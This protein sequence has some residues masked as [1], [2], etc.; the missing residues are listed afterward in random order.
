MKTLIRSCYAFA[1]FV[2][3]VLTVPLFALLWPFAAAYILWGECGC[4]EDGDGLLEG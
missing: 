4:D 1:G 2:I 3:G